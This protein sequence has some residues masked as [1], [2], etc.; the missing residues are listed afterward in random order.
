MG[1]IAHAVSKQRGWEFKLLLQ[2]MFMICSVS[3][4][5]MNVFDIRVLIHVCGPCELD[6]GFRIKF[7]RASVP[8]LLACLVC[9]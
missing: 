8:P 6:F 2:Q 4:Q 7:D 3:G 5:T 9:I 1:Y